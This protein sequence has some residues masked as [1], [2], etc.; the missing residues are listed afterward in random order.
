M[1]AHVVG[2]AAPEL[3]RFLAACRRLPVDRPPV[4]LM[5][6]AGRYLPEYRALRERHDF[7]TLLKTPELAVEVALQPLKRFP[8]DAA[9]VF[10]DIL[11]PLEAM[12]IPLA[13][14]EGEGPRLGRAVTTE[15]DVQELRPVE[16][17]EDLGYVLAAIS[18]LKTEV[19]VPV[20]G[21]AGAPFTLLCYMVEGK[22]VR[23]FPM[24]KAWLWRRPDLFARLMAQLVEVTRRYLLSQVEAGADAVQIFDSWAGILSEADYR[25]FVLPYTKELVASLRSHVP[26]IYFSLGTTAYL[27]ALAEVGADVL[28]LDWRV[29]LH[30]ARARLPEAIALQGNLD[31]AL[32]LADALTLR[33]RVEELLDAWGQRPGLVVNLGHG[34]DP[35][36]PPEQVALLVDTVARRS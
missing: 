33:T 24:V 35:R 19:D 1:P 18:L 14:V 3:P 21:F 17:E 34:V 31:P 5:R 8:L 9:I 30:D 23:D 4:W 29:A 6:Q 32:L 20:I 28:S 27:S 12:G 11:L 7:L 22:G 16:P 10:A 15:E 2:R 13:F 36:T 25:R 26:V